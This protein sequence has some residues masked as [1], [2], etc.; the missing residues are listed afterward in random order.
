MKAADRTSED[1]AEFK[2]LTELAQKHGFTV[3]GKSADNDHDQSADDDEEG[4]MSAA[5]VKQIVADGI[6]AAAADLGLGDKAEAKAKEAADAAEE[7]GVLDQKSMGEFMAQWMKDN[8]RTESKHIF[9]TDQHVD[10]PIEHRGG[11]MTV[12]QKQLFNLLAKSAPEGVIENV[13]K[14]MNDGIDERTLA[15]ASQ[16]GAKQLD[17]LRSSAV[18]GQKVLTTAGSG[19]GLELI[20]TDLASELQMRLYLTSALAAQMVSSEIQMPTDSFTLPL[21]TTRP[22]FLTGSENPGTNPT[23]SD[24]GTDNITLSA[25]KLIGITKYSYEADEDA[26]IAMLPFV[27][28]NLA[29]AAGDALEGAII[30][31][32]TTATHQDSD[33]HAVTNHA[34]KLFKGLRKYALAGSTD[35]SLATGGISEANFLQLKKD[36]LRW[37]VQP[38]DVLCLCGVKGFN[39]FLGLENTLTVEKVGTDAARILTGNAPSLFGIP[40]LVSSQVREDLTGAGIYDG[41]TDTE[42]SFLLIHRPSWIM[43]VRRTFT[44]EVDRDVQQQLNIVV[45]SFRRDFQPLE[46]PSATLPYVVMGRDYTS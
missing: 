4:I 36:M 2:T 20:P 1:N 18:Y 26:I 43:G 8:V 15:N 11:N 9:P 34:S 22:T 16:R 30:N 6:K 14:S 21:R 5:D 29:S 19:T 31:G 23:A 46:T 37:G 33:I 17:L 10:I 32:D 7:A 24:P 41:V 45:A 12:A 38:R 25:A 27:T 28:E 40:I 13:P 44:V 3:D 39:D 42:G 35:R